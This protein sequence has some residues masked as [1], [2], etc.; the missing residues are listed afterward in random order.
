MYI[1][2]TYAA[3]TG[4]QNHMTH[5]FPVTALVPL[6]E[7]HALAMPKPLHYKRTSTKPSA[8]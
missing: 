3:V 2:N 4:L 7:R 1:A 8:S 6:L 5:M